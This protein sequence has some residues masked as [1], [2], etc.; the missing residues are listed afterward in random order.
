MI[1][2]D[3]NETIDKK[4]QFH[5]ILQI[6][7]SDKSEPLKNVCLD[8]ESSAYVL[9]LIKEKKFNEFQIFIDNAYKNWECFKKRI[10]LFCMP[11]S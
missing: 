7:K 5:F 11:N 6:W 4:Y 3:I 8:D 9:S 2:F 1:N 10:Q